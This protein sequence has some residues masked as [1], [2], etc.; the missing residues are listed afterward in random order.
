MEMGH[1]EGSC[2]NC[3]L[4]AVV[5]DARAAQ[6]A[7]SQPARSA[8]VSS[9]ALPRRRRPHA[10][11]EASAGDSVQAIGVKPVQG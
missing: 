1:K 4:L 3:K 8:T 5:L 6:S 7:P 11:S 2:N 10:S 9:S